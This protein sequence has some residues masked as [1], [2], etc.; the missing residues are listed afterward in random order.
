MIGWWPGRRWPRRVGCRR[1]RMG[2]PTSPVPRNSPSGSDGRGA[3]GEM[4]FAQLVRAG[5]RRGL[6]RA[7]DLIIDS[8]PILAW[9]RED[10]DARIGHAPAH[11][12]RGSCTATASTR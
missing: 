3:G 4:L 10:P 11:H 2:A 9:R 8:A 7:R 5:C 1:V 12:A 6:I